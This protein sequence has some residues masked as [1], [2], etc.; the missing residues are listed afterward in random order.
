MDIK[1]L[2]SSFEQSYQPIPLSD[3]FFEKNGFDYVA[4]EHRYYVIN[5]STTMT[6]VKEGDGWGI[7]VANHKGQ[8]YFEGKIH[9]VH[10]FQHI[11]LVCGLSF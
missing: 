4:N 3:G 1:E 6:T 8:R 9:F 11:M 7:S 10:E 2:I 5:D